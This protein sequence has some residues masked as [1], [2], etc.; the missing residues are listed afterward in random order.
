MSI[1]LDEYHQAVKSWLESNED[2]TW[3]KEVLIYPE[4]DGQLPTP[5]ALFAITGWEKS[6]ED[7]G[8]GKCFFDLNCELLVVFS[9]QEV[10]YQ[11]LIRDAVMALSLKID[12]CRFGLPIRGASFLSAQPDGLVPELDDYEAW[13]IQFSQTVEIG[14]VNTVLCAETFN[15]KEIFLGMK[16]NIGPGHEGDYERVYSESA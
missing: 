9:M 15:P 1:T 4:I 14:G 3:L 5:C 6:D 16:P 2:L 13:S 10:E 8:S 11:K 7:D 12:K